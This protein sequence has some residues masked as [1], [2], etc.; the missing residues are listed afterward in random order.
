VSRPGGIGREFVRA[1][2]GEAGVGEDQ[3][4]EAINYLRSLSFLG[5]QVGE[6]DFVYAEDPRDLSKSD[7]LAKRRR[8][9]AEFAYSVHPAFRP[10]LEIHDVDLP[11]GQLA[12]E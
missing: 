11:P 1:L 4:D 5:V 12:F 2:L 7:M 6:R 9:G 3:A 10:Y 8:P